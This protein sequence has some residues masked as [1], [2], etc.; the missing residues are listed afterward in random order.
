VVLAIWQRLRHQKR[1][2]DE[3]RLSKARPI[4]GIARRLRGLTGMK[5]F[6]PHGR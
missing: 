3:D 2:L 5:A 6:P 4:E 1:A